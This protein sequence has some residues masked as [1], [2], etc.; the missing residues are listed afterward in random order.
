MGNKNKWVE[1]PNG[2]KFVAMDKSGSWYSYLSKP[3]CGISI[4]GST[5]N[6]DCID[7]KSV[8]D[9]KNSLH[10]VPAGATHVRVKKGQ[11]KFK[12]AEHVTEIA[13]T[14]LTVHEICR[15]NMKAI[16][17]QR[18]EMVKKFYGIGKG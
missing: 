11:L 12:L 10:E 18:I 15:Q 17:Q 8:L 16:D 6:Y 13:T 3:L 7:L 5:S 14:N 4:W 2:A 9:W 1:L